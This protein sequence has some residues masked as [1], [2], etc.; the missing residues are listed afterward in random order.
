M[1]TKKIKLKISKRRLQQIIREETEKTIVS[2]LEQVPTTPTVPTTST[3]NDQSPG[4]TLTTAQ[5]QATPSG[6][7]SPEDAVKRL[8]N[9]SAQ[10]L[11]RLDYLSKNPPTE[12]EGESGQPN[13]ATQVLNIIKNQPR[14]KKLSVKPLPGGAMVNNIPVSQLM[15]LFQN[16]NES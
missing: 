7:L 10:D 3:T 4:G 8:Q 13:L 14:G 1:K 11:T 2:L 5:A 15:T 12:I 6:P 9:L 16:Q